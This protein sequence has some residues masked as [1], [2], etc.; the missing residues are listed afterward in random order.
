MECIF[1][2]GTELCVQHTSKFF[3]PY[4]INDNLNIELIVSQKNLRA[5]LITL[6]IKIYITNNLIY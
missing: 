2:G 1:L 6:D 4:Y 3:K 5:K